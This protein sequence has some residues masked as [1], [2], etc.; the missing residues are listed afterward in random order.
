MKRR[1]MTAARKR[2]IHEA[3][4]GRC[5]HC[6][7]PVP[8]SGPGVRYDHVIALWI[9][10]DDSDDAIRPAHTSCDKPKTA[11]DIRVIAKIKRIHRRGNGERKPSRL[12]GRKLARHP[13]LK[14]GFD[15]KVKSRALKSKGHHP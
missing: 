15:G 10:G 6:G 1:P 2:R 13:T 8:Q 12:R 11:K 7:E 5:Y 4:E 3:A 14:R 9:K